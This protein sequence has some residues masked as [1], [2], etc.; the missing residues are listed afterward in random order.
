MIRW[1]STGF[2]RPAGIMLLI[3]FLIV[4]TILIS[5]NLGLIRISPIEIARTLAG[6]GTAEQETVLLFFR[7]PRIVI[8]VLVGA[9]LAVSGA[10]LQ[11]IARNGL[12]D[13]GLLGINAGAGLGVATYIVIASSHEG[14]IRLVGGLAQTFMLPV[15]ALVGG[16]L[17]AALIYVLAWKRGVSAVRLILVGI[18]VSIAMNA[19]LL[20]VLTR[21][22]RGQANYTNIWITGSI[23][24]TNWNF[25]LALL[26]WIVVLVPLVIYKARVLNVLNLG[27]T[28]ANGLGMP[29]E[30]ER[31]VLLTAAVGLAA[32]SVAVAGGVGFVG[33]IGPHIARRL[34]GV[35]HKALLPTSALI[36]SLLLIVADTVG[37]NLFAPT[38]IP[39]GV[40]IAVIGAPY[41]LYLLSRSRV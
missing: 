7:L 39:V 3:L 8:A 27:D 16:G 19:V 35:N 41:F 33:L 36:G 4:S 28:L 37:H 18:A 24:G 26:P 6:R 22:T 29:V 15:I 12:A 38:E 23:W 34:V 40:V 9:G 11:G 2:S 10:I 21:M 1:P 30:F 14:S 17:A 5:M 20:V 31:R 32:A 13:P 25:V